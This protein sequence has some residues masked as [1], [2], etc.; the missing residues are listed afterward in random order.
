VPISIQ[1]IRRGLQ[2]LKGPAC[3]VLIL[4]GFILEFIVELPF[5]IVTLAGGKRP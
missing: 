3:V 2:F 1:S 4:S 5:R